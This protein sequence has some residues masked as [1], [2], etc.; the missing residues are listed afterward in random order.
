MFGKKNK[1]EKIVPAKRRTFDSRV[2]IIPQ[3]ETGEEKKTEKLNAFVSPIYGKSV[4]DEVVAPNQSKKGDIDRLYGPFR[5]DK[6]STKEDEINKYGEAYPEFP[7]INKQKEEKFVQKP[8]ENET[9]DVINNVLV[10][11]EDT[12]KYYFNE[13]KYYKDDYKYEKI[14]KINDTDDSDSDYIFDNHVVNEDDFE[15]EKP[16]IKEVVRPEIKKEIRSEINNKVQKDEKEDTEPLLNYRLPPVSML[17]KAPLNKEIDNTWIQENIDKL[18]KTLEEFKINGSV[19]DYTKGPTVTRYE[20]GLSGGVPVKKITNMKENIQMDLAAQSLRIEAPIPGK[21]AVGIEIPNKIRETVYFGDLVTDKFLK[22]KD[23]LLIALGLDI[24]GNPV[25]TSIDTMP[26]GLVAGS[27]RSGKSVFIA[28]IIMSILFRTHPADVK[29]MLID[30]K[31]VDLQQFEGIPHLITPII[32]DPKTAVAGLKWAVEEMERRYD[33]L[34]STRTVNVSDYYE[35]ARKSSNFEAMPRI[36]II[37]EEASDLFISGGPEIEEN[38]LKLTQKARAAGIHVIIATQRPTAKIIN[39][40]IKTNIP[41][42]FAF[43]VPQTMDSMVVLDTPGAEELIGNGDMIYSLNGVMNRIQAAFVSPQEINLVTSFVKSQARPRY[44]FTHEAVLKK[45]M[46]DS[47]DYIDELFE[48]IA[49]YVVNEGYCSTNKIIK[50]FEIGF[51]RAT[52]IVETL[53]KYGV[54]SSN[55]GTKAREV[56][57]SIDDLPLLL[58]EI[59]GA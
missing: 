48:D 36:V 28:S 42:R 57:V 3:I 47:S 31:K 17:N 5:G 50:Q 22:E 30:P 43:K 45:V 21:S 54:V 40:T 27:T 59:L 41:A 49:Y 34:K 8:V 35:R 14:E 11:D 56:L 24:E 18:N 51:N 13:E 44:M 39:G 16:Q 9:Y 32:D 6:K 25:Y 19:T 10:K 58:E 29:L 53:E 55:L 52:Q 15:E 37:I 38:V 20:I 23:P 7:K 46:K 26:H 1:M 33:V 4:K 2:F 12:S